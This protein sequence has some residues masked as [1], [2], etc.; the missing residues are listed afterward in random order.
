MTSFLAGPGLE[1]AHVVSGYDWDALDWGMVVVDI[2]GL[3]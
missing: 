3:H 2:G 1:T